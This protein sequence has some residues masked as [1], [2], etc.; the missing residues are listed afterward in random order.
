VLTTATTLRQFGFVLGGV[1]ALCWPTSA[2]TTSGPSSPP[3]PACH[4]SVD[5]PIR[6]GG[7]VAQASV[8]G[9]SCHD[10]HAGKLQASVGGRTVKYECSP[11]REGVT[12]AG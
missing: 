3:I 1:D 9:V 8:G 11:A 10:Q 5:A 2:T 6:P 12:D 7:V 4:A